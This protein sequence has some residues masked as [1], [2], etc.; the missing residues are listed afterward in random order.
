[1]RQR[2]C[3]VGLGLA[4]VGGGVF[5]VQMLPTEI[6]S[7]GGDGGVG[8][9]ERLRYFDGFNGRHHS[10]IDRVLQ[11]LPGLELGLSGGGNLDGIAGTGIAAFSG[12]AVSDIEGAK[13]GQTDIIALSQS[14]GND[15]EGAID[16]TGS[17]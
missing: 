16:G 12:C 5:L 7:D 10:A 1:M 4:L 3:T 15:I 11:P 6:V 14:I 17:V 2:C 13:P 8:F 9:L